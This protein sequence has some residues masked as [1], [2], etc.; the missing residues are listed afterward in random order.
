[1][2]TPLSILRR[3]DV[4]IADFDPV[5]GHEQGG[6][7]PALVISTDRFNAGPSRLVALLPLT[8]RLRGVPTHVSVAPPDGGLDRSSAILCDQLRILSQGRLDR[9]LGRVSPPILAA[10]ETI[11]RRI[12]DL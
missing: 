6:R 9:R 5:Q 1:L 10:V 2:S 4:W 8:T 3:G 11:L 7:R 12:L